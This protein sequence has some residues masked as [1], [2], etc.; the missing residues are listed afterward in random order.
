M[1]H[2]DPTDDLCPSYLQKNNI[3]QYFTTYIEENNNNKSF[4]SKITATS[5]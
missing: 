1:F 5:A 2:F 4:S 3:K